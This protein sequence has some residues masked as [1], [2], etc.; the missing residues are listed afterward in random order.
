MAGRDPS[1]LR[2]RGFRVS[3]QVWFREFPAD[4]TP[5]RCDNVKHTMMLT[6]GVIRQ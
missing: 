3:S 4:V 6:L 2:G 1:L 5:S